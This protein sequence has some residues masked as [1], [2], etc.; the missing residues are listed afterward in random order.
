MTK[1]YNR[2]LEIKL[3]NTE[4]LGVMARGNGFDY[5]AE[6][7]E[8]C[9]KDLLVNQFHDILP[10]T[11]IAEV[12]QDT[13][14][15]YQEID[16]KLDRIIENSIESLLED[17]VRDEYINVW[18]LLVN[19]RDSIIRLDLADIE[20]RVIIDD[21]GRSVPVQVVENQLIFKPVEPLPAMGINNY[22]IQDASENQQQDVNEKYCW[23]CQGRRNI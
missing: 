14:R 15:M 17:E 22:N 10:G 23:S 7:L 20:N 2:K 3:R 12:Y 21:A 8:S 13:V 11:S 16:E 5:P 19:Q 6:E 4:I 18:N 9:W 1:W